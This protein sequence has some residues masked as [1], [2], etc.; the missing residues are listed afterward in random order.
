MLN[1]WNSSE[2]LNS[3]LSPKMGR[4]CAHTQELKFA[5]KENDDGPCPVCWEAHG[6]H[7]CAQIYLSPGKKS[8]DS[9]SIFTAELGWFHALWTHALHTV[10]PKVTMEIVASACRMW[11]SSEYGP[12]PLFVCPATSTEPSLYPRERSFMSEAGSPRPI[13]LPDK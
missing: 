13:L 8:S 7:S 3:S 5:M 10:P 6:F 12:Q 11:Q 2:P 4:S 9:S 1:Q